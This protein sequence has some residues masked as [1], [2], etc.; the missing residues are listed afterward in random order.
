M[1]IC[2]RIPA[3]LFAWIEPRIRVESGELLHCHNVYPRS[4]ECSF[5][6]NELAREEPQCHIPER[7][8]EALRV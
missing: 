4:N 2:V 3:N 1:L 8:K 7:S 5:L 6:N